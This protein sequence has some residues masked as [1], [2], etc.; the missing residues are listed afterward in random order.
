MQAGKFDKRIDIERREITEGGTGDPVITWIPVAQN[1]PANIEYISGRE[2]LAGIVV[3]SQVVAFIHIRWRNDVDSTMRIKRHIHRR[4][5]PREHELFNIKEVLPVED[6]G[7]PYLRMP[8]T[9]G[10]NDG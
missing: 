10:V 5:T 4:T 1:V 6:D 7:P 3:A 2:F 8:V 9:L